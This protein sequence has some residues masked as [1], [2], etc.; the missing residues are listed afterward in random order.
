MSRTL[1]PSSAN[2]RAVAAPMLPPP[3]EIN[4]TL[5]RRRSIAWA[6]TGSPAPRRRQATRIE[7]VVMHAGEVG[8]RTAATGLRSN[9][10]GAPDRT[11]RD[12]TFDVLRA[13]GLTT[14]FSNP[15]STEISFLA[16][17]PDDLR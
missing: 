14:I 7:S 5:S 13:L 2:S 4:A 9:N 3:P 11:V 16:G 1:A 6:G 17:L 10:G 8:S 12:A 15:G